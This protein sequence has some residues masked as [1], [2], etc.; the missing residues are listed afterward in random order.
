MPDLS[1][2]KTPAP[3]HIITY[4]TLFGTQFFQSFIN[5]IVAFR[6]LPRAQFSVLQQNLFPIYFGIQTALPAVLAITY[7]G[8]HTHLGTVSGISGTLAEVNRWSVL[9]PLATMFVTGLANMVVIGP[10]TTRLMKE[11][12]H[13]E[14]KDGKKSYDAAPHSKEMQRLNK[15]FGKMHGVSSLVNL[16]SFLATMW[17]GVS[18]AER[19]Q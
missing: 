10:A 2:L 5:G 15:A 3:Y 13:Q 19:L 16:V 14:T 4:G 1:I 18:L 9:V 7:P 6:S 11:R 17:Y 8:S 12:K